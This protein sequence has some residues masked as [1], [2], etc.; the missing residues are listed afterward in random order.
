MRHGT[1]II[2]QDTQDSFRACLEACGRMLQCHS[3]DFDKHRKLCYYGQHQGEPTISAP[4]FNSAH[5]MGC[6][7]AC[8]GCGSCSGGCGATA[9]PPIP[10]SETPD[11][12]C[13]NEGLEY[14]IYPNQKNGQNVVYTTGHVSFDPVVMK[15]TQPYH[16]PAQLPNWVSPQLPPSMANNLGTRPMSL[17]IIEAISTLERPASIP[18]RLPVL[19][20]SV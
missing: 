17:Q 13:G 14:A 7:G 8:G 6:A 19:M 10:I 3:V 5:S 4:G 12:S 2:F 20:T 9:E 1:N 15:T 11:T 16:T 18:F